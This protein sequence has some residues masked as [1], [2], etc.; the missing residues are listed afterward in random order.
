MTS[1]AGE[2]LVT[3]NASQSFGHDVTLC[4]IMTKSNRNVRSSCLT[5]TV[6]GT[7]GSLALFSGL[8][9]SIR[10]EFWKD[11]RKEHWLALSVR[12]SCNT[13]GILHPLFGWDP[14]VNQVQ[15]IFS[16]HSF[17]HSHSHL[18][19]IFYIYSTE[20]IKIPIFVF[21]V[22]LDIEIF[23]VAGITTKAPGHGHLNKSQAVGFEPRSHDVRS[24]HHPLI[25]HIF[26][27][28]G[29]WI[30]KKWKFSEICLKNL[31]FTKLWCWFPFAE[32]HRWACLYN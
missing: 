19:L 10:M 11:R 21:I 20:L 22:I 4:L 13:M 12:N 6:H 26:K 28:K 1:I 29:A 30:R 14:L 3:L 16:K 2:Y 25:E 27:R 8:G 23:L 24:W 15:L 31:I 18:P 7:R 9:L 17:T 5:G 32:N